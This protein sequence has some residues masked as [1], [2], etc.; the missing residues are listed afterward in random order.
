MLDVFKNQIIYKLEY[1][2]FVFFLIFF[3]IVMSHDK[4]FM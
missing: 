2:L 4:V 1:Q 3:F